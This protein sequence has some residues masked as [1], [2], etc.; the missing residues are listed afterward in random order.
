MK[1]LISC[2]FKRK[3]IL[4]VTLLFS[5]CLGFFIANTYNYYNSYY[6]CDFNVE[7]ISTFDINK[8]NDVK[9]L[10]EIKASGYNETTKVNKYENIN[11][12]KII[13]NKDF[14][15]TVNEDNSITI[16]TPYKYYDVFFVLSSQ[17][18]SNRAKTFIKDALTKL[19]ID[20][21]VTYKYGSDIV[22]VKNDISKT[23]TG[24]V[25]MLI[26]LISALSIITILYFKKEEDNNPFIYDNENTYHTI[27]HKK[28][29][30]DAFKAVK[31]TRDIT[32]ISL[33]FAL[34]MVCKLIPL[35]SGFGDLGLSFTFLFMALIGIIYGPVYGFLI[36][37]LSDTLGF[38]I[39]SSG[40]FFLGYTLQAALT[41]MIYGL[42]FYKT[43][44][45]FSKVFLCRLLVNMLMNVVLGSICYAMVFTDFSWF[46]KDFNKFV[47]TYITLLSL[48]KNI[49]YLLPQSLFLFYFIKLTSPILYTNNLMNKQ[50]YT[51]IKVFK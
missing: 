26:G 49:V 37:V 36:G 41:G 24:L 19:A 18:M 34:M 21:E 44:I 9:F 42:F 15:V 22:V 47:T 28:Y 12:E 1:N 5:F 48:P 13:K 43:K 27:F 29:W 14:E 33:I 4:I 2:Y 39:N 16:K 38:F 25:T 40:Y 3:W 11:V 30:L 23:I 32:L 6:Q 35:P 7:N 51:H 10:N 45:N 8:L 50:V 20:N 31:K 46:G 17:K